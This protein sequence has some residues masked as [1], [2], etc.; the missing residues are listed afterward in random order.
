LGIRLNMLSDVEMLAQ[1]VGILWNSKGRTSFFCKFVEFLQVMVKL[2]FWT[3]HCLP[4]VHT[5]AK[6]YVAAVATIPVFAL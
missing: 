1:G 4:A 5:D 2:L 6:D 3:C